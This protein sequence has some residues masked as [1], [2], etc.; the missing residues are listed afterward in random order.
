MVGR[1]RGRGLGRAVDASPRSGS[2]IK[3][4]M[5]EMPDFLSFFLMRHFLSLYS[6]I[7]RTFKDLG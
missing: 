1:Q 2:I 5:Q 7:I 4:D 6:N 3:K